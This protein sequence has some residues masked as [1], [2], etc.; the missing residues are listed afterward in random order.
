MLSGNP[1]EPSQWMLLDAVGSIFTG[2][3]KFFLKYR[4][5]GLDKS[6]TL[7][8]ADLKDDQDFLHL[9][10]TDGSRA[11]MPVFFNDNWSDSD[12]DGYDDPDIEDVSAAGPEPKHL[13]AR[14][15]PSG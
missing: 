2:G 15:T 13:P 5:E 14:T 7:G 3:F 6:I 11:R 4:T 9:L 10:V 8:C 12:G 1:D